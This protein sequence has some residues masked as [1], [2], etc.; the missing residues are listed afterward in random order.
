MN[1]RYIVFSP[2]FSGLSNIIMCYELIFAIAYITKRTVILPK[3]EWYIY[4]SASQTNKNDWNSIWEV[5][6]KNVARQEFDLVDIDEIDEVYSKLENLITHKSWVG[7][8]P[9]QIKDVYVPENMLDKTFRNDDVC[10]ICGLSEQEKSSKDF[11]DFLSNRDILDLN[12]PHKY[13]YFPSVLF[14]HFWYQIYPG[15]PVE[16]NRLKDKINLAF[17]YKQKYFDLAQSFKTNI[18]Q[19]NAVHVRR[20][21]FLH[22]REKGI[23]TIATG[24]RLLEALSVVYKKEKP[25]YI[26]SDEGKDGFFDAVKENFN[27]YFLKDMNFIPNKM[28][29]AILDQIMCAKAD[30]FYGTYLST[31]SKRINIMRGLLGKEVFDYKGLNMLGNQNQ[32]YD[33]PFPWTKR[34]DKRWHWDLSS[35]MQWKKE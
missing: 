17:R 14:G 13:I 29:A 24:E 30:R 5:C 9:D 18:G 35:H 11:K 16:R 23:E 32:E 33:T 19:Y 12:V 25:L 34:P 15:G 3:S 28:E 21:D 6:E 2:Y 4:V 1:N 8:F 10:I 31:F 27:V 22:I 20:G 7:N 26:A